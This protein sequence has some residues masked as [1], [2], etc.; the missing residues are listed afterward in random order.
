[1]AMLT[2]APWVTEG[3]RELLHVLV[4]KC[5]GRGWGQGAPCQ[6]RDPGTIAQQLPLPCRVPVSCSGVGGEDG[7]P[8]RCLGDVLGP[9]VPAAGESRRSRPARGGSP[10]QP[11]WLLTCPSP[12]IPAGAMCLQGLSGA[13]TSYSGMDSVEGRSRSGTLN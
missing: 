9:L 10:Q 3:W 13:E 1:M 8:L 4:A 6:D 2:L 7:H 11:Q 12:P 5:G